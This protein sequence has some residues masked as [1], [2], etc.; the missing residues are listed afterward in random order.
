MSQNEKQR[1][2]QGMKSDAFPYLDK[3]SHIDCAK[4]DA[5]K[6]T[7][8]TKIEEII[9]PVGYPNLDKIIYKCM[10][11]WM[12]RSI[13]QQI[14]IARRDNDHTKLATWLEIKGRFLTE[15]S[16]LGDAKACYAEAH[17]LYCDLKLQREVGRTFAASA[18]LLVLRDEPIAA[19]ESV[20][21]ECIVYQTTHFGPKHPDTLASKYYLATGLSLM[22]NRA[23]EVKMLLRKCSESLSNLENPQELRIHFEYGLAKHRCGENV[24]STMENIFTRQKA[25]L[26]DHHPHL[27]DTKKF[28]A[29]LR[30]QA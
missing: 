8:R 21:N 22:R 15:Q 26:V 11:E 2:I 9:A 4:S 16:Q 3:L 6:H 19:W 5:S 23:K 30:G 20:L 14:R 28:L 25:M 10:N 13:D 18:Y 24:L 7:D 17:D 27:D 29:E 12:G 1:F